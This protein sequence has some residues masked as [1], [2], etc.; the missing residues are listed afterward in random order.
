[1]SVPHAKPQAG[2]LENSFP[3]HERS[4]ENHDLLYQNSIK[5][6]EDYFIF[7]MIDNFSKC[8]GFTVLKIFCCIVLY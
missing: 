1:M 3:Q 8:D 7:C 6:N 5:K 2:F 4:G